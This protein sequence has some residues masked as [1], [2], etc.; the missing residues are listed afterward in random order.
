MRRKISAY[1]ERTV[2][3]AQ[4]VS[5]DPHRRERNPQTFSTLKMHELG[6]FEAKK[7]FQTLKRFSFY[8]HI[9]LSLN[10]KLLQAS[11]GCCLHSTQDSK[12]TRN[13]N[14]CQKGITIF[15]DDDCY[16]VSID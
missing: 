3:R 2:K 9:S 16:F 14:Y 10:C 8:D 15:E 13:M 7:H 4:T 6:N 12:W 1:A 11:F 5:E